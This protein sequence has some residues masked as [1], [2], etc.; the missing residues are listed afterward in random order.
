MGNRG[1][2]SKRSL[3][4]GLLLAI[5]P[6]FAACPS[7]EAVSVPAE[8]YSNE[9]RSFVQ[10]DFKLDLLFVIDNSESMREEQEELGRRIGAMAQELIHPA[11]SEN[12]PDE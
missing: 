4:P 1:R 9:E 11:P 10:G 7:P 2:H 3:V 8:Q 12:G 5:A 6:L